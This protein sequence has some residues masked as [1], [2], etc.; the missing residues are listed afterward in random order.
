VALWWR[1]RQF[2]RTAALITLAA[3]ITFGLW[4]L[5]GIALYGNPIYPLIFHGLEWDSGRAALFSFNERS[6]LKDGAWWQIPVLP[7]AAT[8]LGQDLTD[9]YG[10]TAGLWLLTLWIAL[11]IVEPWLDE[12]AR[13]LGRLSVALV[14]P[15][16]VMW[17]VL[18]AYSVVGQQTRLMLVALPFCAA[19]GAVTL[20]GL[21]RFPRKPLHLDWMIRV[22]FLVT[23]VLTTLDLVRNFSRDQAAPYLLGLISAQD[24]R[25]ANLSSYPLMIDRLAQLPPGTRVRFIFE[26]RA[27]DCPA[28]IVCI[29]DLLFDHWSR[30]QAAGATA[31]ETLAAYRAAGDDYWLVFD[32]GYQAYLAVSQRLAID[33]GL[34]AALEQA[35]VPV[36]TDGFNYT[37][38]TWRE[39]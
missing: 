25:I 19:G 27:Y 26:P 37:L 31:A 28:Q 12:R 14:V 3:V 10:F 23:A 8:I 20:H 11:P 38:Y 15:V 13:A 2:P 32:T 24:Y 21:A 22:L 4:A 34:P 35:F 9:G 36:W 33:Q 6:L 39:S 5:K 17:G 30:P 18:S 29:G 1:P 7:L 16:I